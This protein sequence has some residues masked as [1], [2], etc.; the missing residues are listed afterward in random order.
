M[1][2]LNTIKGVIF[3]LDGTLVSSSL[4]FTQIRRDIGCPQHVDILSFIE[5]LPEEEKVE[6]EDIVIQH[7]LN[8]A[9]NA[10]LLKNGKRM[11]DQVH[12]A[13]LPMAIVTRNCRRA[14]YIKMANNHIDVP[15]VI[16]REDAPAK[17]DP[18][19]LLDIAAQWG[20]PVENILYVGDY[21]YDQQAAER[22]G[23]KWVLV[24]S[25]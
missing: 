16:T 8:D 25:N 15:L 18:S 6:A 7:E 9:G 20:I 11:L 12:A 13:Q 23:M 17:P 24:N 5:S 22:A 3:D 19:A 4:N 2:N 21:I 10:E 1:L 14:T